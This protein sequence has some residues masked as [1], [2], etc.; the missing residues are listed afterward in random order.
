MFHLPYDSQPVSLPPSSTAEHLKLQSSTNSTYSSSSSS[1]NLT[2]KAVVDA[3]SGILYNRFDQLYTLPMQITGQPSE[4]FFLLVD[5]GSADTW[6]RG[7]NCTS[8]QLTGERPS[9]GVASQPTAKPSSN[10]NLTAIPNSGFFI[11]YFVGSVKGSVF[12]GSL[13]I[14]G[15]T[16]RNDNLLMGLTTSQDRMSYL[17]DGTLGLGFESIS[18]IKKVVAGLATGTTTT[19]GG[20]TDFFG[21]LG[22]ANSTN[23]NQN[24]FGIYLSNLR[25]KDNGEIALGTYNPARYTGPISWFPLVSAS[26]WMFDAG[27]LRWGVIDGSSSGG[28][29]VTGFGATLKGNV[30][31]DTGS[32]F[33]IFDQVCVYCVHEVMSQHV[34]AVCV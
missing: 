25:D 33:S 4:Y 14:Y 16:R 2:R 9:C 24:M 12:R 21:G 22:Y 30:I 19:V 5:T 23:P 26:Y 32:A 18:Q 27:Q 34:T 31:A 29:V 8:T 13:G 3:Q 11:T 10:T 1:S 20:T 15:A 17:A 6:I 7:E 28:Q